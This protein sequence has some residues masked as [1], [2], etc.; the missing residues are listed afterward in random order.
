MADK[1]LEQ[2]PLV[3]EMRSSPTSP[4]VDVIELTGFPGDSD[5]P[6]YQRLYLTPTLNYCAE[7][8]VVD[9][10]YS[11]TVPRDSS[12]LPGYEV[13]VATIRRETAVDYIWTSFDGRR[14]NEF[15]LDVR[16]ESR[17]FGANVRQFER[18]DVPQETCWGASC[19]P[20]KCL[21]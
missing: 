2:H 16:L 1:P 18:S 14:P 8:A 21:Q 17:A 15:D 6:G 19:E 10:L 9:M 5:R 11:T 4:P 12:P 7:F 13:V 20:R 3:S